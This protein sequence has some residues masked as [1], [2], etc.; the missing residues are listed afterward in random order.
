MI[1]SPSGTIYV[2]G[3]L[4]AKAKFLT[5]LPSSEKTLRNY[6]IVAQELI[7]EFILKKIQI[8]RIDQRAHSIL[9]TKSY[10]TVKELEWSLTS[11]PL[12]K[13]NST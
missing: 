9:F 4:S 12:V 13:V 8:S 11:E 3:G 2:A 5:L 1:N 7:V 6:K 10:F